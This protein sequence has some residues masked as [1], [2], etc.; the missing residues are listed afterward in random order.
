MLIASPVANVE[1]PSPTT[2]SPASTPT[3]AW[4]SSSSVASRMP[5]AARTARSASS[6][7][8]CGTPNAAM[9]ASPANFST[10]PPCC[11]MHCD[12]CSKNRSTRRRTISGSVLETRPVESTR[13]TN[14]TVA[15][16]RSTPTSVETSEVTCCFR[17]G[18][19]PG[20]A[21]AHPLD[22]PGRR[23][24]PRHAVSI[25][26]V[27]D[28][29]VFK[30]YDVRGIY[31]TE[32]DEEGAYAIGRAY[33][34]HFEPQ[35]IAVGRD[36]RLSS[37]SMQQAVIGGRGRRRAPTC[38]TSGSSAPRWSTSRSA[39]SASTAASPSPPRTI[40]RSTRG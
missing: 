17:A 35:R 6:S 12:A 15:S 39:S 25:R 34:E 20:R 22:G 3:R 2:T 30:A 7:C 31:P 16:L 19:P 24:L 11:W 1:S 14:K 29:K 33:V 8:A 37:P 27:L 13:S 26:A 38:S 40:P 23:F 21:A 5:S 18:E 28:P 9:T 10:M 32:L 4:R 36:M